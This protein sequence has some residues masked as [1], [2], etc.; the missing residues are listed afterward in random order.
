M[1]KILSMF[2]VLFLLSV[3]LSAQVLRGL[4]KDVT[5]AGVPVAL[6]SSDLIVWWFLIQVKSGNTGKI[7]VIETQSG[8]SIAITLEIPVTGS[9]LPF[10]SVPGLAR[11]NLKNV[12]IDSTVDGE[13]VNVHYILR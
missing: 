12:Q 13:G 4:T 1:K 2:L 10:Y 5:T 8:N 6:T 7:T 11:V 9:A 3:P